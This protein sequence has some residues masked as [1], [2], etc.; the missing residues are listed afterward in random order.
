MSSPIQQRRTFLIVTRRLS[1]FAIAFGVLV[2]ASSLFGA[3][4]YGPTDPFR[5]LQVVAGI[6]LLI[7]GVVARRRSGRSLRDL[8]PDLAPETDKQ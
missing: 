1:T 3:L 4:V 7:G 6:A 2:G 5:Y 8:A